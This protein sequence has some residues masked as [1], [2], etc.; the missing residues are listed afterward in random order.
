MIL[1][2][3]QH[4]LDSLLPE[5]NILKI[6]GSSL[7]QKRSEITKALIRKV[8]SGLIHSAET[9]LK[10]SESL[11][12]KTHSAESKAK[13][14]LAKIGEKKILILVKFVLLKLKRK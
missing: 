2:R 13:M 5:Y 8:K 11:K 9:K 4:F 12:G 7:G 6:T 10:I 1:L 3:E 14:N